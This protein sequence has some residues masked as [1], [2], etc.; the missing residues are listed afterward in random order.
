MN[1]AKVTFSIVWQ[2]KYVFEYNISTDRA[3]HTDEHF[4]DC[5]V[6]FSGV[7]YQIQQYATRMKIIPIALQS[8]NYTPREKFP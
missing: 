1:T 2:S 4:Q 3:R 5:R 8:V 6:T 7:G